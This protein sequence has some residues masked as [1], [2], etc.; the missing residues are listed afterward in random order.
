MPGQSLCSPAWSHLRLMGNQA[1]F[2]E[3]GAYFV[4]RVRP[5]IKILFSS[6][7]LALFLVA[8]CGGGSMSSVAPTPDPAP[9]PTPT[10]GTAVDVVT[11]HYDNLR[12][13]QNLTE[14]Q[15]TATANVQQAKFGLLGSLVVD[16]HVD[17]QPLYLSKLPIPNKGTKNVVY[18]V[19]EHNSVYAFDADTV[20]GNTSTIL[21]K[22]SVMAPGESTGDDRNCGQ[23]TPE[24]GVTG[25]PV[26]DRAR[27]AI[28]LV[29]MSKDS[30][31]N[32][33]HRLHA[34]DLTTGSELFGGP[35][36]I[37]A[38]VAGA[39]ANSIN[40]NV[41]F[42]AKQ[43]K[44][45]TGLLQINDTIYTAWASHCDRP[46]YTSWVMSYNAGTLQQSSAVNLVP[47]GN[48]GGIWMSGTAPAARRRR[49]NLLSSSAMG[50]STLRWMHRV[51][52][53]I[54][55]A[56]TALQ[57]FRL[58]HRSSFRIISHPSTPSANPMRTSISGRGDRCSCRI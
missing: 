47:N 27:N 13:G 23:V 14:T 3:D 1:A 17:A 29:S 9:A 26:I 28:Y 44:E 36:T 51:F 40:G 11:Y 15:L 41:V 22:T 33:I 43:Y 56:A 54:R 12:T 39:G 19:T 49:R 10:S 55:T 4:Y 8:G 46:P 2:S 30:G 31:G 50:I 48:D 52:R 20:S 24:I 58:P 53:P 37:A 34:L 45:R 25:T 16:G 32:Y 18:V 57:E 42:D 38:S 6:T 21:W 7:V 35:T 5:R